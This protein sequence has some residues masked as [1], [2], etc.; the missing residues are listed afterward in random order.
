[1]PD[2][3][4][5]NI[6]DGTLIEAD[7]EAFRAYLLGFNGW[8]HAIFKEVVKDKTSNQL[9]A[10]FGL[11]IKTVMDFVQTN[12][13]DTSEFLKLLVKDDPSGLPLT[14][15]LL[16]L[17]FYSACPIFNEKGEKITLSKANRKQASKHLDDCM[18][19]LAN[20]GIYV[21][22]PNPNWRNENESAHTF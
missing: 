11:L 2:N 20:R 14:K 22:N 8:Y 4:L 19:L 5:V 3:N 21:P 7:S 6:K 17:I 12:G 16:K 15:D 13:I 9:G 1:M 10:H 18:V